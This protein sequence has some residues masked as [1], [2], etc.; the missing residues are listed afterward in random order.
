MA[1]TASPERPQRRSARRAAHSRAI[2]EAAHRLVAEKGEDFTTQ[3]LIK[4]AGVALQT[5]YRHYGS[6]DQLLLAVIGDLI[7]DHCRGLAEAGR[8]YPDP[9][10]RLRFYITSTVGTLAD[11]DGEAPRFL[12][13]QHWRLHQDHPHEIT[14]ATRPYTDLVL[15]TL[16]EGRATGVLPPGDSERDAWLVTKTV[17]A[18]FHHYA[19][20]PDGPGIEAAAEDVSHFCLAA[21]GAAPPAP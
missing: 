21:V 17:I 6:K 15:S 19:F 11:T 12:T 10:E 20:M 4:E 1:T 9:V 14:A 16:A 5:F 2:L 3:E 8:A 18:V 13:S 7:T